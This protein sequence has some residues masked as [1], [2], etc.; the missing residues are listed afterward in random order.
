M[1]RVLSRLQVSILLSARDK[2][3]P[4]D[5]SDEPCDLLIGESLLSVFGWTP[6]LA[7]PGLDRLAYCRFLRDRVGPAAYDE[8]HAAA[9][10]AVERLAAR[11]LVEPVRGPDAGLLGVNLT[12][13]GLLF[14]LGVSDAE[15]TRH[16]ERKSGY[17]G[18]LPV[19]VTWEGRRR[20][21]FSPNGF[22]RRKG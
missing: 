1:D 16:Y 15:L 19:D 4:E 9:L 14:D 5:E 17:R 2:H 11:G 21:P 18:P 6:E 22:P 3:P 13:A 8:A 12:K 20:R 7:N 10:L